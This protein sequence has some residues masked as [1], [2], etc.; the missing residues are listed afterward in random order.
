M[1]ASVILNAAR[2]LLQDAAAATW[3]DPQLLDN[4]NAAERRI[5]TLKP[6]AHTVKGPLSLVSGVHQ[7]LPATGTLVLEVIEDY[8]TGVRVRQVDKELLD[9]SNQF[10]PNATHE[11]YVEEWTFDPREPKAFDVLP[12]NDGTG[13][14]L[15]LYATTPTAL[16]ASTDPLNLDDSY[17][18]ALKSFTLSES[19]AHTS[20]KQDI[21]KA[22]YYDKLGKAALGISVQAAGAA[23]PK[24]RTPGGS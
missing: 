4:L 17:E 7:T 14:V 3:S 12:P 5:C 24:S 15:V 8:A 1:L 6:T 11:N 19:Y 16:T 21:V 23:G 10:W 20:A 2:F 13:Q 22:D 9:E 18:D